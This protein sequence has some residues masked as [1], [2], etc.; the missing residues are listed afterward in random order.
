MDIQEIN[1]D[2]DSTDNLQV[3]VSVFNEYFQL[4]KKLSHKTIILIVIIMPVL[5]I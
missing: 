4:L 1:V 3:I 2:G 5:V